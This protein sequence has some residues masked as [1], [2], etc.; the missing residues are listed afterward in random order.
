MASIALDR[1]K[2]GD[3]VLVRRA[4]D[5]HQIW[6]EWVILT[7]ALQPGEFYVATPDSEVFKANLNLPNPHLSDAIKLNPFRDIPANVS[8]ND[9]YFVQ[10]SGSMDGFSLR[11]S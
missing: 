10:E 6:H 4:K 3:S 8:E 9:V 1:L 5:P 7:A 2:F 11:N